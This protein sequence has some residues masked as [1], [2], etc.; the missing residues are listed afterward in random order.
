MVKQGHTVTVFSLSDDKRKNPKSDIWKT[1]FASRKLPLPLRFFVA[2]FRIAILAS[3]SDFVFANGL[4]QEV[5]IS[6]LIVKRPSLAKIVGDP[7]WERY[8]NS[9]GEGSLTIEDFN[10]V[11]L[12]LLIRLQRE[13]LRWSLNRFD[14][15]TAPGEALIQLIKNWKV[16]TPIFLI[17]NGTRCT[18]EVSTSVL[19][20]S[21]S[22]SRLVPWKNLE[23]FVRSASSGD[24]KIAI[25]GEGPEKTQL[26]KL[27]DSLNVKVDFLGELDS[28]GV[29]K[30]LQSS[31]TFVN[32]SSYEG[33]SFSLIE[34]MME[35]KA[36]I[37]SDIQG[38]TDVIEH[39]V[40]G[41]VVALKSTSELTRAIRECVDN[42]EY[43]AQL[44]KKAREIAQI[45]YCE[46]KQ[47]EKMMNT[48]LQLEL[49]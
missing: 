38:N 2:I 43:A 6:T 21:I 28:V 39:G 46:E 41:I 34:A 18:S 13:F 33:L 49:R 36:C 30:A 42:P 14:L 8:R 31:K 15:V 5:A 20:D 26:M 27:S 35:G 32:L 7:V 17:E 19:Y 12:A 1:Q 3:Q 45:Y 25:C 11:Q 44:G 4:H 29:R 40:N 48:L 22:V 16:A 24:L 10:N 37:V 23:I 9:S 47:L